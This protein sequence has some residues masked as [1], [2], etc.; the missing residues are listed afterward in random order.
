MPRSTSRRI[1][2]HALALGFLLAIGL[3]WA[4]LMAASLLRAELPDEAAGR[5]LA[6]FPMHDRG[7]NGY[8]AAARAEAAIVGTL[9]L[10]NMVIVQ[11]NTPGLARRLR[12]AG[13]VAVYRA[14]A[15][16]TFSL[17]GCTGLPQGV[18]SLRKL[19]A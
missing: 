19:G 14:E 13:A 11:E 1:S 5:L 15:F 3:A 2:G 8:R 18:F 17:A 4:G 9:W 10:P 12:Q 7:G 16:E 6:V